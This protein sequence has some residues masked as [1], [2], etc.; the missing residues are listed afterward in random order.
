[1]RQSTLKRRQNSREDEPMTRKQM[2]D[3][4]ARRTMRVMLETAKAEVVASKPN[5]LAGVSPT[6][7]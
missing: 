2:G 7:L 6:K 1:L 5:R 4:D 3:G